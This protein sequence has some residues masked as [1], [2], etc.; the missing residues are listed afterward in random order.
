MVLQEAQ[1]PQA[2]PTI[3]AIGLTSDP[4]GQGVKPATIPIHNSFHY[5]YVSSPNL[6]KQSIVVQM[7]WLRLLYYLNMNFTYLIR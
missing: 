3:K 7:G 1:S 5:L 4:V 2:Q 6:L